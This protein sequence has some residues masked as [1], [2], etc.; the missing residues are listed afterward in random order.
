VAEFPA[1]ATATAAMIS[2]VGDGR[3]LIF[4]LFF[5]LML[6]LLMAAIYLK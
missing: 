4:L 5:A 6:A 3:F 1:E 2:D